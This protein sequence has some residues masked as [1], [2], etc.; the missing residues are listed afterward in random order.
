M[1]PQ[2]IFIVTGVSPDVQY[3]RAAGWNGL[4]QI[5]GS[6]PES[7]WALFRAEYRLAQVEGDDGELETACQYQIDFRRV[8]AEVEA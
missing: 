1:D 8:S 2:E 7:Q 3:A 4:R 6:E 5:L